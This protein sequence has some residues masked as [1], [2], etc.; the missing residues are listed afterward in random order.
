[1]LPRSDFKSRSPIINIYA[2]DSSSQA[3]CASLIYG[4]SSSFSGKRHINL[5]EIIGLEKL[6]SKNHL[7]SI[8]TKKSLQSSKLSAQTDTHSFLCDLIPSISTNFL[9]ANSQNILL[10]SSIFIVATLDLLKLSIKLREK[11]QRKKTPG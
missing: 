11:K 10:L 5:F 1:M 8:P 2:E 9:L 6:W 4:H 3:D 7:Q